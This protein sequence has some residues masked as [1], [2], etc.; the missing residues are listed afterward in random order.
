MRD[1]TELPPFCM[2]PPKLLFFDEPN[3]DRDEFPFELDP[4]KSDFLRSACAESVQATTT[5]AASRQVRSLCGTFMRLTFFCDMSRLF[6]EHIS[7]NGLIRSCYR[8]NGA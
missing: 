1:F 8:K 3:A 7:M 6:R 5:T 2:S 4:P